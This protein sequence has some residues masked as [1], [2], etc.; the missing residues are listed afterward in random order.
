MWASITSLKW[1]QSKK[2]PFWPKIDWVVAI[3]SH[4]HTST[5]STLQGQHCEFHQ[6]L[7]NNY[8]MLS[9]SWLCC[10]LWSHAKN[11]SIQPQ[12]NGVM[13]ISVY[14]AEKEWLFYGHN[15]STANFKLT[16]M[17]LD[18]L[19]YLNQLPLFEPHEQVELI[20]KWCGHGNASE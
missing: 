7:F 17:A 8:E 2:K 13:V 3:L 19:L 14:F 9:W 5:D 20:T 15:S 16:R 1:I 12:I 11:E 18:Y 4:Q 6:F 10:V